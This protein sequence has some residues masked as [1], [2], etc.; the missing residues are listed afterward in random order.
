MDGC[1]CKMCDPAVAAGRNIEIV[2]EDDS[3]EVDGNDEDAEL[4]LWMGGSNEG[5]VGEDFLRREEGGLL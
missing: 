2:E 3:E 5:N 4:L 1:S